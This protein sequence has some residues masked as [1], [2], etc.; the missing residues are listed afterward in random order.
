M[1]IH[2]IVSICN[3]LVLDIDSKNERT[4]ALVLDIDRKKERTTALVKI[5]PPWTMVVALK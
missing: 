3:N 4:T 2:T 5:D 1:L